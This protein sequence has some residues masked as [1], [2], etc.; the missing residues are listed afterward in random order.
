M[1]DKSDVFDSIDRRTFLSGLGTAGAAG[2]AGCTSLTGGSS[3]EFPSEDIEMTVPWAAGG[4][5]DR[6]ARQLASVGESHT[7]SSVYVTNKTG[8]GGV[9]G[10]NAIKNS[11]TT[12]Y[13]VG[14]I[15]STLMVLH[16]YGRTDITYEDFDPIMQY[17]A[18][19]ASI[20]VHEDAP[21]DT[22]EGLVEHAKNN[23]VSVGTAGPG[24][25]WHLAAV[26]FA[27]QADI[28]F[29][30][31]TY[32]GSAPAVTAVV[33]GE[34]DATTTSI[35]E[36]APQVE[37][38]P[39][40]FIASMGEDRHYQFPEV[41]T[42]VEK[43]YD[44]NLS[45]WRALVTPAGVDDSR[46]STLEEIFTSTYEDEDFQSFMETNGFNLAYKNS[47]DL[48]DF[49]QSQHESIGQVVENANVESQ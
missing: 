13:S 42:L 28:E 47:Q 2:L 37:D 22:V 7:D 39:L 15:A 45:A 26:G 38:G 43:G 32:D 9:V 30:H 8:G 23:T 46:L 19:P 21:Y 40:K 31:V 49:M 29:K 33:N 25:I 11:A 3:E 18:D 4:G 36:A 24:D 5:T 16:H 10:F 27:Q 48:G 1:T 35:P 41:P 17:N 20:T 14:V 12:G 34:V 44:W 6:T